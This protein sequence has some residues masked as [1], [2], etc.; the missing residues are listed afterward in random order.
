MIKTGDKWLTDKYYIRLAEGWARIS[1]INIKSE[2]LVLTSDGWTSSSIKST[3]KTIDKTQVSKT[4]VGFN[5]H[6]S[7]QDILDSQ[8][9]QLEVIHII[10]KYEKLLAFTLN[11]PGYVI[12]ANASQTAYIYV[13]L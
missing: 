11:K 10:P 13:K 12:V 7:T 6:S 3:A 5:L 8:R 4:N 9:K 2:L 1:D